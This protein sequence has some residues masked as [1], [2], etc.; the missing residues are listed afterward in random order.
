MAFEGFAFNINFNYAKVVRIKPSTTQLGVI[1]NTP[2]LIKD[3]MNNQFGEQPPNSGEINF[4]INRDPVSLQSNSRR[5]QAFVEDINEIVNNPG[6]L[7]S[8]DIK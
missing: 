1:W 6:Y 2:V 8:G 7:L 5:K 3:S 4:V